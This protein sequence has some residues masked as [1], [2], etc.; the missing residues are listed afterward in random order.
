MYIFKDVGSYHSMEVGIHEIEHQV[1]VSVIFCPDDILKADD[2]FMTRQFL[3]ENDFSKRS[4]C[5]R[6]I[7]KCIEIL[8]ESHNVLGLFVDGFPHDTVGSLSYTN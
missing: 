3:Q 2:I 4:L 1:N 8:L 5:I 7:L 6:C